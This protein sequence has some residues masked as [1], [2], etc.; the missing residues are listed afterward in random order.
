MAFEYNWKN[1][2]ANFGPPLPNQ[3]DS[4]TH[5]TFEIILKKRNKYIALRRPKGIPEHELPPQ[6]KSHPKGLLYFCHNL[7]R[8]GESVEDCVK[9]IVRDQ[10]GVSV[11]DTKVV[12]IDSSVQ[13]KDNQWSFNPT[14]IVELKETPAINELITEVIEFDK[15]TIPDDF[16][17]WSK[18]ELKEVLEDYD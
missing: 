7:I 2:E 8:Y 15:N 9:R 6:A 4:G 16:A 1:N 3:V 17:W 10:A 14:V 5:I 13:E 12:Y 18:K 11:K